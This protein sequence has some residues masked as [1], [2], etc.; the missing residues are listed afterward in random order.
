[1]DLRKYF[2]LGQGTVFALRGR[3]LQLGRREPGHLLLRRQH[4]AARV[5]PTARIAGNEGFFA[6][7]ELRIPLIDIMK[8]PLG[9]LGPVRGTLFAGIGGAQFKGEPYDFST[10]DAGISFVNDPIFGEPVDGFRL[11]DGRASY[12]IGLQFFFLGYPMHFDW[13][14]L[15]D[16]QVHSP[17]A[18]RLLDRLRLLIGYPNRRHR[19]T[20]STEDPPRTP[21]VSCASIRRRSESVRSASSASLCVSALTGPSRALPFDGAVEPRDNLPCSA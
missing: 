3:G 12:G 8:T 10:S 7:A 9:I 4:G 6:N 15:T 21:R 2:R 5:T 20:E 17:L 14:K 19:A 11:V 16:F 13:T 1:M 18:L